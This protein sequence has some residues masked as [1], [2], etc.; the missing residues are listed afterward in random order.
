MKHLKLYE[1]YNVTFASEEEPSQDMHLVMIRD[2]DVY[3][4]SFNGY[5]GAADRQ[6]KLYLEKGYKVAYFGPDLEL[7]RELVD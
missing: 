2:K 3:G 5:D 4:D 6:I 7:A 1:E